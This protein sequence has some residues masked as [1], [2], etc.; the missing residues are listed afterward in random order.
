MEASRAEAIH[1]K[2]MATTGR[3]APKSR[4]ASFGNLNDG[5]IDLRNRCRFHRSI[6][7]GHKTKDQRNTQTD[8]PRPHARFLRI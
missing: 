1:G 3:P 5:T 7:S 4:P 8:S 6:S 2:R